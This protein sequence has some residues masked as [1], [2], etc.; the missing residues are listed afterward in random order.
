MVEIVDFKSRDQ[1]I[2]EDVV[3][4]LEHYLAMA[5]RGELVSLGIA[6]ILNTGEVCTT[7]CRTDNLAT[8]LGSMAL[9]QHR[10]MMHTKIINE[11]IT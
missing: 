1:R 5:K 11:S 10:A 3:A 7:T 6:G 8:L 9:M 4:T 2:N